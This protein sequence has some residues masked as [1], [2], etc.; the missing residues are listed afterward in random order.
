MIASMNMRPLLFGVA[1]LVMLLNLEQESATSLRFG[2]ITV[3]WKSDK[4]EKTGL[5]VHDTFA[6][7][8]SL[9]LQRRQLGEQ[10]L[11]D[12]ADRKALG[13]RFSQRDYVLN[14][15]FPRA[16]EPCVLER[17]LQARPNQTLK[18]L[19]WAV[20]RRRVQLVTASSPT[21][22]VTADGTPISSNGSSISI[23]SAT[24]TKPKQATT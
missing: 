21:M 8:E 5:Q 20:R 14:H 6:F 17:I 22:S 19:W 15:S 3:E 9:A 1:A 7:D 18:S 23:V 24:R 2:P 16:W 4:A 11:Q 13:S 10:L 12:M